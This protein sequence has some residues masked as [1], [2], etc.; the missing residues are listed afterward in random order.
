MAVRGRNSEGYPDPT[1]ETAIRR[2]D[3]PLKDWELK[4]AFGCMR[5]ADGSPIERRD[6]VYIPGAPNPPGFSGLY[7]VIGFDL[8]SETVMVESPTGSVRKVD[9]NELSRW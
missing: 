2:G 9:P 7:R 1:A 8:R 6:V 4:K 3:M 5:Y